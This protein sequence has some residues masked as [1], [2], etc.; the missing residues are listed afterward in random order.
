MRIADFS[1]GTR[2]ISGFLF[3]AF[4]VALAGATG[5]VVSRTQEKEMDVVLLDKMPFKDVAMEAII[6][7]IR[8][9][10]AAAEFLINNQGLDEIGLSLQ[11]S[12]DSFDMWI[13]MVLWGTES[14]EYRNSVAGATYKK[15]GMDMVTPA[16]TAQMISM[17][18]EVLSNHEKMA[19]E[20]MALKQTRLETLKYDVLISGSYINISTWIL[21]KELDH[22]K[23]V[24]AL[25]LSIKE[26]RPFTEELDPTR[27]SFGQWF[28]SY[29]VDDQNLMNLLHR[30]EEPHK[31]LHQ[32]GEEINASTSRA[33]KNALFTSQVEPILDEIKGVFHNFQEYV[34]PVLEDLEKQQ[35]D[36]MTALDATSLTLIDQL[37]DLE[38]L[39]DEEMAA[40]MVNSDRAAV[41]GRRI[42]IL[43]AFTC[44]VLAIL[45]GLFLTKG[46]T[47]PLNLGVEFAT[48]IS[49][50]D[51]TAQLALHQKD[52]I[53]LLANS[54]VVMKDSLQSIISQVLQGAENVD[55]GS[56]QL[57]TTGSAVVTGGER[58]G[59]FG[60]GNFIIHG[61]DDLQYRS[62]CR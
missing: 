6:D 2:L 35:S 54:L 14:D 9:R 33:Q 45:L 55:N 47:R 5:I 52:E 19:D 36:R 28:Y 34:T 51:L 62:E 59:Q 31:R 30:V 48:A 42:I 3:I 61:R 32:L 15:S 20:V 43:I 10:D 8:T 23:W 21:Q 37:D 58:S 11:E 18:E 13:S 50:G 53:G 12:L 7:V 40:A 38:I 60:G 57:S 41:I 4:L 24:D 1:I 39:V 44:M 22:L 29:D 46:I 26:G 17:A 49:R 56:Q 27:C 25:L 16:G